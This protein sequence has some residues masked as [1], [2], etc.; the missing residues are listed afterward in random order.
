MKGGPKEQVVTNK[1][2]PDQAQWNSDVRNQ[3]RGVGNQ[4]YTP[5]TGQTV[6]QADPYSR[7]AAGGTADVAQRLQGMNFGGGMPSLQP[8][9]QAGATGAAAMGGDPNAINSLMNPYQ[10][11]V[12]DAMHPEYDRLRAQAS[13]GANDQATAGG[14]F[15][16]ARH[17]LLTGERL[18]DIDRTETQNTANLLQGGYQNMMNNAGAAA[19]LGLGAGNL[20]SQHSLGT[21]QLGIDANR[22]ATD[23]LGQQ[24][25]QGDYFRGINQQQL[26]STHSA[27][28]ERRDWG[29]RNL[30]AMNSVNLPYG[31]TQTQPMYNNKF[32]A[33]AGGAATGFGMGGPLGAGIGGMAGLLFG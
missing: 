24:F 12:I 13:L 9:N 3:A 20:F 28:N 27:F 23:A 7:W 18:G 21:G 31:N 32:G 1:V 22:A 8:Y 6:A 15:G 25:N 11:Q 4:P 16:G 26:D 17:A 19:N 5:F 14:A 2:D 29:L 33:V 10:H 30:N